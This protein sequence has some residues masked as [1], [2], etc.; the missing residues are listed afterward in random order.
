M[1]S[2]LSESRR[3]HND[4]LRTELGVEL[5]YPSLADGLRALF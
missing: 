4:R 3:L 5:R 1:L 2:Y